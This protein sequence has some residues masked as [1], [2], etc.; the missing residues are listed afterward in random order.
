M[1]EK[2]NIHPWHFKRMISDELKRYTDDQNI[3]N[4]QIKGGQN[5]ITSLDMNS[6][7]NPYQKEITTPDGYWYFLNGHSAYGGNDKVGP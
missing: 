1:A 3:L 5:S 2:S 4:A 6:V 7:D